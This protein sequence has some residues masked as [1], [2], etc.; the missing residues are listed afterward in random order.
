MQG[1]LTFGF[2]VA[3]AGAVFAWLTYQ[4]VAD[5]AFA[6][7][8]KGRRVPRLQPVLTRHRRIVY[9]F[10]SAAGLGLICLAGLIFV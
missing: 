9:G 10:W 7:G 8:P 5:P 4:D 2:L 1:V 6:R 3:V